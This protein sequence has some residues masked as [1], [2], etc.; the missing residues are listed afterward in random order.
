MKSR[1][2]VRQLVSS[3]LWTLLVLWIAMVVSV[4]WVIQHETDHLDGKVYMD[5]LPDLKRWTHL[6]EFNRQTGSLVRDQR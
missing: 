4:A 2:M 3:T 5:R 1:S 6:D